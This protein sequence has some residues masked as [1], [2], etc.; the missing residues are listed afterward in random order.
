MV[1]GHSGQCGAPAFRFADDRHAKTVERPN[2]DTVRHLVPE[3]SANPLLELVPGIPREGQQQQFRRAAVA[4]SN[5]PARFRDHHRGLAATG[6][7]DHQVA[8]FV[9]DHRPALLVRKR[10]CLHA[11]KERS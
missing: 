3:T 2:G 8:V 4:S 7:G 9:D 5:K 6:R 1:L 11:V 10:S